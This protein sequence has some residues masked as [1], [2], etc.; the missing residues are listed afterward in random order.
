M[1]DRLIVLGG[2]AGAHGPLLEI[3][4]G[5]SPDLSVP[6]LVTVHV[7]AGTRSRLPQIL[8]AAGPLAARHPRHGEVLQAGSILVA[9]PDRHLVVHDGVVYLSRGPRENR[10]RPAVDPMFTTAARWHGPGVIGVVLSGA[11]DDGAAGA[12]AI[13]AQDGVVIAQDPQ[14]A[15]HPSMP[16]AAVDAV[17]RIRSMS[18]LDIAPVLNEWAAQS[19][20]TTPGPE[21]EPLTRWETE[22]VDP[23]EVQPRAETAGDPSAISC[24]EC[25]GGMFEVP[26][27]EASLNYIC[28]VGH[29]WSPETLMQAQREASEESLYGAAAKLHEEARV[30]RRLAQFH[31]ELSD[32]DAVDLEARAKRAEGQAQQI[33]ALLLG[34]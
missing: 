24:P 11:L 9:P 12:A 7:A 18:S 13:A 14:E 2:S 20:G 10:H 3:V 33:Q 25:H 17:R 19:A 16:Q 29:S 23:T 15:L 31:D 8:E 26:L 30:L 28:H 32:Q 5:L 4:A 6:V 22:V 34:D 21:P 1:P 27:R